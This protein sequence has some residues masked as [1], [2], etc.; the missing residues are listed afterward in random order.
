MLV[1]VALACSIL[2]ITGQDFW[3]FTIPDGPSSDL[4]CSAQPGASLM[5]MVPPSRS[6]LRPARHGRR[7]GPGRRRRMASA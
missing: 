1:L 6:P 5:P 2:W 4:P 7:H 3:S